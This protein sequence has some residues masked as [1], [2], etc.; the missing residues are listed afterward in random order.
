MFF[1]KLSALG[2]QLSATKEKSPCSALSAP[3]KI[4]QLVEQSDQCVSKRMDK[5]L[6]VSAYSAMGGRHKKNI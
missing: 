1:L 5:K 6:S 4:G 3:F 2:L